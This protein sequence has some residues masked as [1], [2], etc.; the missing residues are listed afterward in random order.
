M[1]RR[2]KIEHT[3]GKHA[4]PAHFVADTDTCSSS[5]ERPGTPHPNGHGTVV[6]AGAARWRRREVEQGTEQTP[7]GGAAVTADVGTGQPRQVRN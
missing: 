3:Q 5:V 6:S 7:D 1:V 2:M 4:R